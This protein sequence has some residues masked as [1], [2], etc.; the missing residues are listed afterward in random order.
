LRA[1]QWQLLAA[2]DIRNNFS[3]CGSFCSVWTAART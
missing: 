1:S 2:A 3:S